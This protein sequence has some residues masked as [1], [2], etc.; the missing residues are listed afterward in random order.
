MPHLLL[1]QIVRYT[2]RCDYRYF[3]RQMTLAESTGLPMFL[4]MRAAADDFHDIVSRNRQRFS[5]GVV[6]SFTG[7]REEAKQLLDLDL[8]I[9]INGWCVYV[10]YTEFLS[11][12]FIFMFLTL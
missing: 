4:H 7:T 11:V 6:H 10:K 8:Y 3:E 9:G 2:D 12:L 5:G 1:R